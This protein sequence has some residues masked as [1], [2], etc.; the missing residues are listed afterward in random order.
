MIN[1]KRKGKPKLKPYFNL[2]NKFLLFIDNEYEYN[3]KGY[4]T[5]KKLYYFLI[6]LKYAKV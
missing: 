2:R 3:G 6:S 5:Y 4:L 1:D